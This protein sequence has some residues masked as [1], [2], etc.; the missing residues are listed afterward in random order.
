MTLT[1]LQIIT[2]GKRHELG[3]SF[4]QPTVIANVNTQM[5]VAREETFGPLVPMATFR[6]EDEVIDAGND[7]EFGLASYVFTA[8]AER[9]QRVIH[10]D[11]GR[12]GEA[13]AATTSA[14]REPGGDEFR[15]P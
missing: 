1:H 6:T 8:D 2:G 4:F 7:T 14:P 10:L 12:I 5:K 3:G 11:K 13:E 9:A 15:L